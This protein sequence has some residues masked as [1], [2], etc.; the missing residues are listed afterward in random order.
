MSINVLPAATDLAVRVEDPP[1]FDPALVREIDRIWADE[2][3]GGGRFDGTVL[4][5]AA[6]DATEIRAFSAPY[7]FVFAQLLRRD[8]FEGQQLWPLA[9]SGFTRCASEVLVGRRSGA[10]SQFP[11]CWE[12]VPSGSLEQEDYRDQV[13][14]ELE[15][16]S[17]LP[18]DSVI[19]LAPI[20][21]FED[22]E[23]RTLEIG[24]RLEIGP[25]WREAPL[26]GS[27]YDGIEWV[28][29]GKLLH[30]LG[31]SSAV[32]MSVALA[33]AATDISGERLS[34]PR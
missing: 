21:I 1:A 23:E 6:W 20:A 5:A 3:Q 16:E 25:Q 11:G 15:E 2:G 18:R 32:P 26:G 7:R 19:E 8:L 30:F 4:C 28:A 34:P 13:L 14:R 29:G 10:V 12:L 22:A 9:V 31:S 27:E 17:G 24:L 33:L